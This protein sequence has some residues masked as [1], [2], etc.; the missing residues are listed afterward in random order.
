MTLCAFL[1]FSTET[2]AQQPTTRI[3]I[4]SNDSV[5]KWVANAP[6]GN[7]RELSV[8]KGTVIDFDN[9]SHSIVQT[10]SMCGRGNCG[11]GVEMYYHPNGMM[12]SKGAYGYTTN[13]DS[14]K[15][16]SSDGFLDYIDKDGYWYYWNEQGFLT[17][18]EKWV[19]GKLTETI[20]YKTTRLNAVKNNKTKQ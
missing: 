15:E 9:G 12:A 18:R 1:A 8:E 2:G 7:I 10:Q 16:A 4:T 5:Y 13:I 11:N 19:K 6:S 17:K 14:L 3:I 20:H